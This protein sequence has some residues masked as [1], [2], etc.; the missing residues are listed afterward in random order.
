VGLRFSTEY[1]GDLLLPTKPVV[2]S[3]EAA[4]FFVA[5][6]VLSHLQTA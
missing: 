5:E 1:R 3:L 4:G 2:F 6:A